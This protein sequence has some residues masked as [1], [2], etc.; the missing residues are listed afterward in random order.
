MIKILKVFAAY[1]GLLVLLMLIS[2]LAGSTVLAAITPLLIMI[3]VVNYNVTIVV[4]VFS[5]VAFVYIVIMLICQ[6]ISAI[7]KAQ[8]TDKETDN[9]DN[10]E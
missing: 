7:R 3:G 4:M 1:V 8:V 6:Y 10:K 9:E 2:L 5:S